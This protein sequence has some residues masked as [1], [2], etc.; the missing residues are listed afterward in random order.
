M[1]FL[2]RLP[3]IKIAWMNPVSGYLPDTYPQLSFRAY[4]PTRAFTPVTLITADFY[5]PPPPP[6]A[7]P[8][9]PTHTHTHTHTHTTHLFSDYFMCSWILYLFYLLAFFNALFKV[10][11]SESKFGLDRIYAIWQ[12]WVSLFTLC[13]TLVLI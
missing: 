8:T 2:Y 3:D 6:P 7:P 4:Y 1:S 12:F 10:N 13:F 11:A 9:P 5:H